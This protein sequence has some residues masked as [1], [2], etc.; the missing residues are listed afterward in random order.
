MAAHTNPQGSDPVAF[1]AA[2]PGALIDMDAAG[3]PSTLEFN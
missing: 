2:D 1:I 3:L